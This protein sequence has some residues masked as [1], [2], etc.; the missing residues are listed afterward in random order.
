MRI[1]LLV[2]SRTELTRPIRYDA[3]VMT[4]QSELMLVIRAVTLLELVLRCR[5][6]RKHSSSVSKE[7]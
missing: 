6:I 2:V 4:L 1:R 3:K 5:S 7:T